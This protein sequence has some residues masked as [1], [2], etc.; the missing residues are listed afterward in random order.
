MY[1]VVNEYKNGD[2]Y[3]HLETKDL[4]EAKKCAKF[5][6]FT[7]KRDKCDARVV[8]VEKEAYESGFYEEIDWR[9]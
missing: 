3:I 7:N 6:D 8:V 2:G 4:E 1:L 5:E 9:N